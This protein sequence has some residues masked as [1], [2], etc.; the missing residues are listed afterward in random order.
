VYRNNAMTSKS[1]T[2]KMSQTF[3]IAQFARDNN[4]DA[5]RARASLRRAMRANASRVPNVVDDE[6]AR[7]AHTFNA[8]WT[9]NVRDKT[10]VARIIM[11]DA[12]FARYVAKNA[13]N[14]DA[15]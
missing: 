15:S 5:K 11:T 7:V 10:R 6:N 9:F 12:Q 8:S 1:D 2:N 4:I 13:K 14:D 3:K